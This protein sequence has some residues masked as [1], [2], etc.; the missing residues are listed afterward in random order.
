MNKIIIKG[1]KENNLKNVNLMILRNKVVCFVGVSGSGK[2]TIAFDIIAREGQRQYFESLPA[3]AR[4][5]LQKSNRPAVDEISGISSTIVIGQ[6]RIVGNPRSTVGT[7]TEAYTYLRLLYSRVGL[8]S[9]DSSYYSFNHPNGACHK[10][11]GLGRVIEL[12]PQKLIDFTKSLNDG[13]LLHS[14]WRVGGRMWSIIRATHYFDMDK[15][16][17][18]F[19]KKDV[20]KLLYAPKQL[21]QDESKYGANK[22]T[23][24]GIITRL[25][26]KDRHDRDE[27]GYLKMKNCSDCLGG[28]LNQKALSVKIKSKN[29]GEIGN[30]FL[31]TCLEFVKSIDLPQAM[32]IKPRLEAQLKNLI[33]AGVGY[34]SLNRSTETLSGGEARRVK[35]ARQMG[36]DLIETIYV[37]DEP[38]AGLHPKDI[39][40]V[41]KNLFKLRDRGN[42]VLVVEHDP[43]VIKK[44]D[45]LIEVGPGGGKNGGMIIAE[46]PLKEILNNSD[47]IL[48]PYLR[49]GLNDSSTKEKRRPRVS[50]AIINAR[51]NNLKGLDVNI[52][53]GLLVALT[54]VS[55]SGK[56]SLVEEI[57]DQQ[58]GKI[59][60]IDQNPV[61][62]NKRACVGTYTG[63][64]DAIRRIFAKEHQI[65][66]SLFSFNAS[67][68]CEECHGQGYLDL[69]MNFLGNVKIH[70]ESCN[71]SRY[72]AKILGLKYKGKNITDVLKM[73]AAETS[74]LFEDTEVRTK[75]QLLIDVGLDYLEIGQSLD[76]L[77]GGES[78]RL[79]LA[80]KLQKKG[81]VYIL[82]EPTSGL[83]FA[84]IEK[85]L[86]LLNR[87]V[88]NGNT[89]LVI[90]HNL[91][92]I[93]NADWIIDLGPE[94]GEKGG[95]LIA[96]GPPAKIAATKNSDTGR[97]LKDL[98][99][100]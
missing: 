27:L 44:A 90:E 11:K 8:P 15:K 2:S 72:K 43:S 65:A 30:M 60:L 55:G 84:D 32:V 62:T 94:G 77:S 85:L 24:S 73:T 56:S 45:Y 38:T 67:G 89:V 71:G 33:D 42:T 82:D 80:S 14:E 96:E 53:T 76:T 74:E 18:D 34:L 87:L 47:S 20:E 46:G 19:A 49:N 4:R 51:R 92:V 17:K 22:W 100:S 39:D 29:I 69:E 98:I 99:K 7:L 23:Y 26:N 81:E 79:K 48:A 64:F 50:L 59:V 25:S 10:C 12:D 95:Y 13:A 83:H 36:C 31:P 66:A 70:C 58:G 21:W 57:V 37:F 28:R 86:M 68:A 40:K 97:Y 63:I 78:Q 41:I 88:D 52:P 93:K 91:D 3:F 61:G 35:L 5:Y 1:A 54:G 9:L 16:I 6:D 75:T